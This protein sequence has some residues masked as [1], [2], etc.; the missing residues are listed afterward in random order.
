M[1]LFSHQK[2]NFL[3]IM[4]SW[5]K[6]TLLKFSLSI[7]VNLLS[8]KSDQLILLSQ[9]GPNLENT[10]SVFISLILKILQII[11]SNCR[12]HCEIFPRFSSIQRCDRRLA[13]IPTPSHCLSALAELLLGVRLPVRRRRLP[14]LL[15][16]LLWRQRSAHVRQ[17]Q[18]LQVGSKPG[19][20]AEPPA[21]QP[22]VSSLHLEVLRFYTN[23]RKSTIYVKTWFFL[24]VQSANIQCVK[25]SLAMICNLRIKKL[26]QM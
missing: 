2:C 17:Q 25:L 11:A 4:F 3:G 1:S 26:G 16:H 19:R 23:N 10:V 24:P 6:K 7:F 8:F 22:V 14:V 13:A 5:N 12:R 20:A 15:H 9:V 18:L 21:W